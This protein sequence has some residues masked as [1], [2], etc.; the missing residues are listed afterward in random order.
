MTMPLDETKKCYMC[1]KESPQ[2]ILA[3][4]N[5]FGG[6]PDLDTRPPEMLRSTM[7]WW[8]QE[9]PFCG[10]VAGSL[11]E[12]TKITPEFLKS[13]MYTTCNGRAFQSPLAAQFY[14]QYLI[15][16]E[17]GDT[18]G[19]FSAALHGAWACDDWDTVENAVHCRLLALEQLDKIL[20]EHPNDTQEL[21]VARADLLRR[22]GQFDRVVQEYAGRQFREDIL[23]I[24]I[25]FQIEK[26]NAHDTGCYCLDDIP[27]Y[28]R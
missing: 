28:R 2:T 24:I 15:L 12:E 11:D 22:T 13:Q 3:S 18:G 27:A 16:S 6:T 23:N 17:D 5:T 19:A 9:C 14:K 25:A 1:S 4:S 21:A 8:I 10:Y 20:S 7:D 26:A